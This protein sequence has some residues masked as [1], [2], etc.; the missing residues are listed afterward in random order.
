M[1]RGRKDTLPTI[2][3]EFSLTG[4]GVFL[5]K[6]TEVA[7]YSGAFELPVGGKSPHHG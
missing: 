5:A 2:K 6:F 1:Q 7:G 4:G 3:P